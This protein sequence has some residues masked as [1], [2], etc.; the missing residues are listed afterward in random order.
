M[1]GI[2]GGISDVP[3]GGPLRPTLAF[4]V[5]IREQV[6][7]DSTGITDSGPAEG[8]GKDATLAS[9]I[10]GLEMRIQT[11]ESRLPRPGSTLRAGYEL[12]DTTTYE[13]GPW[14]RGA[15]R[16]LTDFGK[17]FVLLPRIFTD[18]RYPLPWHVRLG[19]PFLGLLFFFS[20]YLMPLGLANIP[21]LG[22]VFD[23]AIAGLF[24]WLI[25]R[26]VRHYRKVSMDL[27]ESWR[28]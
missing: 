28:N 23:L 22:K 16:G 1:E 19:V 20:A 5:S 15:L 14:W 18:P 17:D 24:F 26:E 11:L 7:M 27:P 3:N 9:R 2:G 12:P 13:R 6:R 25:W 8:V 21:I 4:P 10:A